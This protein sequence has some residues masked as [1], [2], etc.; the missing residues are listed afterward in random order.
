MGV[1]FGDADTDG[2]ID[3]VDFN[4]LAVHFDP[5]GLN[6]NNGRNRGDFDGDRGVDITDFNIVAQNYAPGG[7]GS[8]SSNRSTSETVVS[9]S[10]QFFTAPLSKTTPVPTASGIDHAADTSGQQQV[11][12]SGQRVHRLTATPAVV[13]DLFSRASSSGGQ[14]EN[15]D[16]MDLLARSGASRLRYAFATYFGDDAS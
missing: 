12:A 7:Y 10:N 4:T 3:I 11:V 2:D 9:N 15:E 8:Q 1:E 6:P 13:D 5:F 14:S 16:V